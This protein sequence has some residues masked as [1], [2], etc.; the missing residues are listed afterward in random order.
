MG[1]EPATGAQ[2]RGERTALIGI[3]IGVVGVA[4]GVAMPIL[5]QVEPWAWRAMFC[6][7]TLVLFSGAGLVLYENL[8]QAQRNA[9]AKAA[10]TLLIGFG[11]LIACTWIV[12]VSL[13]RRRTMS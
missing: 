2:A 10:L 9:D 1:G 12:W 6:I 4:V 8:A 13:R 5:F 7:A 3:A 11:W